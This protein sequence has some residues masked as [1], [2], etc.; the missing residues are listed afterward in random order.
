[1]TETLTGPPG[2]RR[3]VAL[4]A[5]SSLKIGGPADYLLTVANAEQAA[6]ALRWATASNLPCRWLGGGSN[7]LI[8]DHGVAGLVARF[9]GSGVALPTSSGGPVVVEAGRTFANLARTLARA[10]WSGLE[11]AANVPGCVGGAVV[12]N[13]GAFGSTV[14]DALDWAEVVDSRGVLTRLTPDDLGYAYRSSHL[15]RGELG[16]L[17]VVRAAFRVQPA[18]PE[19]ARALVGELQRQRTSSQP[20]Q[21]SLGSIFANPT[22]DYAGRLVEAAGLK[23]QTEGGAQIS[24]LHANF[25]VNHGRASALDVYRLLRTMQEQVFHQAQVWL[26]PEIE[27]FGRWSDEQRAALL[28]PTPSGGAA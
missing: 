19:R 5:L 10:G 4:A 13:A 20:R 15:K 7:L 16:N 2:L 18:A 8:S 26:R 1:V 21:L 23:G 24:T 12:N 14:A 25:I 11:W 9:G 27:L 22:G 17:A 6:A 3:G 28:G